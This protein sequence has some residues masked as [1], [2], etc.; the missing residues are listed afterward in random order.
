MRFSAVRS[1]A[2]FAAPA[3]LVLAGAFWLGGCQPFVKHAR[4]SFDT[5]GLTVE[6]TGWDTLRAAPRFVRRTSLGGAQ[7][8]RPET[9][10][11]HV[12]GADYDTLYAGPAAA[13]PLP[14]RRLASREPLLVEACGAFK[15]KGNRNERAHPGSA[16]FRAHPKST[17]FRALCEQTTVFASPKRVR[18]AESQITFPQGADFQRGRYDVRFIAERRAFEDTTW[19]RMDASAAP[20]GYLLARAESAGGQG[21][22]RVPVD[23]SGRGAF[24]LA[25]HAGYGDFQ[26]HLRSAME[27]AGAVQEGKTPPAASV[28]FE[29]HAGLNG[30]P[31]Q[32]VSRE[33]KAVRR[34]APAE[35]A[36]RVQLFAQSA[37]EEI[38]RRL[39]EDRGEDDWEKEWDETKTRATVVNWRFDRLNE[40]YEIDLR[41]RW[42]EGGNFFDHDDRYTLEGALTVE[43]GSRRARFT[44]ERGN[45]RAVRR[46]RRV[47]DGDALPLGPLDE[48]AEDT[49]SEVEE[50]RLRDLANRRAPRRHR[51]SSHDSRR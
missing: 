35:R 44:G 1:V 41:V 23:A 30:S 4:T 12:F 50:E 8:V 39:H 34:L 17:S 40:R 11:V 13:I 7:P 2:S 29:L 19:E 28:A 37:A 48:P 24:D 38:A 9:T 26:Y 21:T 14:D 49:M 31:P 15:R 32:P 46:W 10:F 16:S 36:R 27:H 42:G 5:A 47:V 45:R 33:R 3:L 6:R 20:S 18:V 25:R 51:R 43:N 22:V